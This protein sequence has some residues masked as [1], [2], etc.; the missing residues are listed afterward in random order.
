MSEQDRPREFICQCHRTI[1]DSGYDVSVKQKVVKYSAYKKAQAEI[2]KLKE[3]YRKLCDD[4]GE[5]GQVL[6]HS[7]KICMEN[8]AK[9]FKLKAKQEKLVEALRKCVSAWGDYAPKQ[10]KAREALNEARDAL[11]LATKGEK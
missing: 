7:D 8:Y 9:I 1:N 10:G 6:S 2:D 4:Y 11:D 3:D 5:Q